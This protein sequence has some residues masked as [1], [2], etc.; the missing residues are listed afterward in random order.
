M[1]HKISPHIDKI[2]TNG[3]TI[4]AV[5]FRA[6]A[7]NGGQG[8]LFAYAPGQRERFFIWDGRPDWRQLPMR[9]LPRHY[10]EVMRWYWYHRKAA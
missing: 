4:P 6:S 10:R 9:R 7:L 1:T 8:T 3:I 2:T 5:L